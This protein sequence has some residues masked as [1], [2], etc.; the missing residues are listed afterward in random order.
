MMESQKLKLIKEQIDRND[1]DESRLLLKAKDA[2][3]SAATK[4]GLT[5]PLE[6]IY[7]IEFYELQKHWRA[8]LRTNYLTEVFYEV[9]YNANIMETRV[10]TYQL[11]KEVVIS[12]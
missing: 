6:E 2:V 1:K 7:C 5:L 12:D 3:I 8:I 11:M 10:R 9:T 4:Q